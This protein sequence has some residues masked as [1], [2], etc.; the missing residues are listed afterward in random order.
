MAD[1]D[2]DALTAAG[3]TLTFSTCLCVFGSLCKRQK[4]KPSK[5]SEHLTEFV[6]HV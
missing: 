3:V 5:S 1:M 4:L 2:K 6:D